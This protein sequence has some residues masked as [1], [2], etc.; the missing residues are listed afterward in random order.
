MTRLNNKLKALLIITSV[1]IL[2]FSLGGCA[3]R[4]EKRNSFLR[5]GVRLYEAG[6][7]KKAVLE[8]KNALQ[9]D[10]D[11]APGYFYLGRAYLKQGDINNAKG[12]LSKALQLDKGLDE[13]R[14]DLGAILAMTKQ[15]E[16]ALET[17]KPLL[18]KDPAHARALLIAAHAYLALKKPDKAIESLEKI[19]QPEK[20]KEALFAFAGAYDMMGDTEKVKEY[21]HQYQ[22]AAPDDPTSYQLLS[23]IY[24]KEEQLQNAEDQIRKLVEQKKAVPPYPL[25]L[26]KFFVDTHQ[27]K[28]ATAEFDRLTKENPKENS[29]KFAYAEF[30]FKNKRLDQCRALLSEAVQN[31]PDSWTAR[32]YLVKLY[33]AQAKPDDALKE[34]NDFL[35][36]GVKEGKVE[37]LLKKGQ[38]MAERDQWE[39][40]LHQCDL[41]LAIESTN[42]YAHLLKGKILLQTGRPDEAIIRLRQVVDT[43]PSEPEG[44]LFLAR[45][46]AVSGDIPLAIEELKHGLK[47]LPENTSLRMEL[48]RYYQRER[49]WE[50]ALEAANIGLERLPENLYFLIQKGRMLSV[51]KKLDQ[52][53][54]VFK[55]IIESH[56]QESVGYLELGRLRR[57]AGDSGKAIALFEKTLHLQGNKAT[58]LT[59]LV[60]TYLATKQEEKAETVCKE[61]LKESPENAFLLTT[62]G[63]IYLKQKEYP[64]AE[65]HFKAAIEASPDWDR[66]HYS[67]VALYAQTSRLQEAADNL[68]EMY[69]K[70]PRSVR[71]G[72]TLCVLY[73]ELGQYEKAIALLEDLVVKYPDVVTINNNLAYLYAE[74]VPGGE[75]LKKALEYAHKALT[76]APDNPQV[77]DTVAW[78]EFKSGNTDKAMKYADSAAKLAEKDP[79]I[80]YHAGLIS[81]RIGN[82]E[83]ARKYLSKAIELGGLKEEYAK[84]CERELK[85]L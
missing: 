40:A 16:K 25:L 41:A 28:K 38:I 49:E 55:S 74:H 30:L 46:L 53:E 20:N 80:N 18:N 14:L 17:I 59:L 11:F 15:G 23:T 26:C 73:Q 75:R 65:K 33:L 7:Y 62:L 81:A 60:E 82:N 21:M 79:M 5:K 63:S 51:L 44:Y 32:D 13:A 31:T 45:A 39:E 12:N 61:M 2:V 70:N 8:F 36:R 67:L 22:Q 72:F 27:E 50:N 56:P 69:V 10:P 58:A 35:Q 3:S 42:P 68:Q 64:K 24:V 1:L 57:A 34:L 71:T 52:A 19:D 77:L 9:L 6:N 43:K 29:Y 85:S 78:V 47:S 48:I 84:E 66:P 4:E 83:T 37:A 76:R 54:K